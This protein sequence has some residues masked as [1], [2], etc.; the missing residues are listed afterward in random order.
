MKDMLILQENIFFHLRHK[1]LINNILF[2]LDLVAIIVPPRHGQ[3]VHY[4]RDGT[5]N[6]FKKS[7]VLLLVKCPFFLETINREYVI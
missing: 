3:Y 2:Y 5:L 6:K 4:L 7:N 1:I